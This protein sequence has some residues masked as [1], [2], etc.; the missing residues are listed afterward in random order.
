MCRLDSISHVNQ[1]EVGD[2]DSWT[3]DRASQSVRQ[4]S[5]VGQARESQVVRV[6][7]RAD[8]AEN[9]SPSLQQVLSRALSSESDDREGGSGACGTQ[10]GV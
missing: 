3:G 6:R 4:A 1:D 5:Q 2:L 8:V 10:V 9:G 7:D